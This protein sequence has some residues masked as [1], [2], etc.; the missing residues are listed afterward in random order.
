[1]R[2]VETQISFALPKNETI[3]RSKRK[4]RIEVFLW[5]LLNG[6]AKWMSISSIHMVTCGLEVNVVGF[7]SLYGCVF[8]AFLGLVGIFLA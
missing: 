1:M 5:V 8:P 3:V 4:G 7:V 6:A 2:M